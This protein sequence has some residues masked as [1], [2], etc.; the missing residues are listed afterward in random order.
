M[1]KVLVLMLVFGFASMATAGLSLWVNGAPSESSDIYLISSDVIW[2]DV[3][4]DGSVDQSFGY[5]SIQGGPGSWTGGYAMGPAA[6]VS[7]A[8][9]YY[10]GPYPGLGDTWVLIDA[11]ADTSKNQV[12]IISSYEFHCDDLGDV[13]LNYVDSA[14]GL[15][16][17]LIIHQIPE[18]MTIGLLGLGGLF[19]RR[20]K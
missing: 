15:M 20:R 10:Y 11:Y 1:K 3:Y 8:Y 7:Y 19:L 6:T 12:G 5:I 4:N 18:P 16:D 13:T 2:I 14:L 9:T 17:T